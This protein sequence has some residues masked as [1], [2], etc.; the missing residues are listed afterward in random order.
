VICVKDFTEGK[1]A[2]QKD[3]LQKAR[4]GTK[5]RGF[6]RTGGRRFFPQRKRRKG[7]G[8]GR[9]QWHEFQKE[10]PPT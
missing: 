10:F 5:K 3:S 9:K 8:D 7:R 4:K 6:Y 1:K 2:R